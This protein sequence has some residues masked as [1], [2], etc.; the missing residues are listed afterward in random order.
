MCLVEN[1]SEKNEVKKR[2]QLNLKLTDELT[3]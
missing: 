1:K 3:K 2:K